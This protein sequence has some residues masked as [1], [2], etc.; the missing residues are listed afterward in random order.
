[1]TTTTKTK[2]V[3]LNNIKL[4]SNPISFVKEMNPVDLNF[5]NPFSKPNEYKNIEL[6]RKA[7]LPEMP[8]VDTP[9]N[10]TTVLN[11]RHEPTVNYKEEHFEL[12]DIMFAYDD[13]RTKGTLYL[14]YWNDGIVESN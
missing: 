6:V 10:V 11:Y 2:C 8:K 4:T 12:F 9:T 3:D 13:D 1:M 14:G 7:V 5:I